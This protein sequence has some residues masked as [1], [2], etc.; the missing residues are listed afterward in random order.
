MSDFT[1]PLIVR[2]EQRERSGR[3]VYTVMQPFTY[4]VGKKNS[5]LEIEVPAGFETDFASTP[6]YARWMISPG[7]LH[8][9]ATVLH[10][11]L[12]RGVAIHPKVFINRKVADDIL[13][14]AMEVL[15]VPMARRTII[16]VSVRLFGQ[17][18]WQ[19]GEATC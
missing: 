19:D 5:G 15:K 13:L 7:G 11:A 4:H 10:D 16:Y 8:A 12:Y 3:G 9:K 6:W 2:V 18:F 14:E 1:S 17:P